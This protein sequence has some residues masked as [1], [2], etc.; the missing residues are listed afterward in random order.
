MASGR[1]LLHT[2]PAQRLTLKALLALPVLE[3]HAKRLWPNG[4]GRAA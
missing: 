4:T 1:A 2:D 3:S